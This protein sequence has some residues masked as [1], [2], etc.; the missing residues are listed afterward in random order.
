M[1]VSLHDFRGKWV[2]LYFYPK[3]FTHGCT[4]EAHSF[5]RALAQYDQKNAVI[6]GVSL[7][8]TGSHK[9]LCAKEGLHFKLLADTQ[10]KVA[11]MYD[12]QMQHGGTTVAARNTFV[13]NPQGE[14]VKVFLH[15]DPTAHSQQALAALDGLEGS[16]V[17]Q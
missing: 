16:A 3:D 10:H 12:S 6:V 8:T 9:E 14:V 4:I 5:Q 17:S 13:I 15:V 7:D 1:P 11:A 2:V